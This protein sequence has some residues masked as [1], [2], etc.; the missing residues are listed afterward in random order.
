MEHCFVRYW[1]SE[2]SLGLFPE[3]SRFRRWCGWLVETSLFQNAVLMM[4]LIGAV[5]MSIELD[6]D[7]SGNILS[8]Q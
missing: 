5:T 4:I 7:A 2:S 8:P 3:N 6:A 1:K